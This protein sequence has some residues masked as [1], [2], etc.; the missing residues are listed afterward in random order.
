MATGAVPLSLLLCNVLGCRLVLNLREAGRKKSRGTVMSMGKPTILSFSATGDTESAYD[1]NDSTGHG[2]IPVDHSFLRQ[3]KAVSSTMPY[4]EFEMSTSSISMS[5]SIS[6]CNSSESH[7][8]TPSSSTPFRQHY[9]QMLTVPMPLPPSMFRPSSFAD[10]ELVSSSRARASTVSLSP[11]PYS[12]MSRE[13]PLPTLP[14]SRPEASQPDSP[15][16]F[17]DFTYTRGTQ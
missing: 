16:S 6:F 5:P 3:S 10:P 13:R 15:N 2:Q 14:T 1:S 11:A 4:T 17:L 7:L 9:A 12:S 8:Q